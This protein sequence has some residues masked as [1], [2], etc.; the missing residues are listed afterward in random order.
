MSESNS[1]CQRDGCNNEF[2]VLPHKKRRGLGKF[3][4]HKCYGLDK[5]GKKL[6]EEHKQK[7]GEAT[8][9]MWEEGVFDAP[10]I[11]EA[12]AEQGRSTK[13]SKRTD[14]QREQMSEARK[15]KDVSHLHTPEA[16]EKR[17]QKLLGRKQSP[18]S[19]RKRSVALKGREFSDMHRQRLSD[20]GR[21]REDIQ[22]ENS[23]WW[24]GGVE[25]DPYPDEFTPYL[26]RKIRKRDNHECQCCGVNVYRS[27]FGHVHHIDGNKQNCDDKNLVLVCMSCHNSIHG[28][29][30]IEND[31]IL[32]FRSMLHY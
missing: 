4:S 9:Q 7:I 24:R 1:M 14:E 12:Y 22:G 26:K 15:G 23:S 19:N 5:R 18:E 17:R 25:D 16:I 28:F 32:A 11:R 6:S 13:G 29:S 31:A 27:R 3:C 2:Y 10:H 21:M 30:T 8:K 20:A